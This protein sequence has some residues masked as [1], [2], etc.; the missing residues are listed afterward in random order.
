MGKGNFGIPNYG[1]IPIPHCLLESVQ[2]RILSSDKKR[3]F[4]SYCS[5]RKQ[6]SRYMKIIFP[7]NFEEISTTV[8]DR[9]K[10]GIV[11]KG[12]IVKGK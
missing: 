1:I 9:K 12:L 2:C 5:P 10:V 11:F 7:R 3:D 6:F 4:Y 8:W